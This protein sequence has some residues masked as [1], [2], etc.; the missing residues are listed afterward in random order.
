[1]LFPG[2]GS[3]ESSSSSKKQVHVAATI[4]RR[5]HTF[6][7]QA[8]VCAIQVVIVV[9]GTDGGRNHVI[10]PACRKI[11]WARSD[12]DRQTHFVRNYIQGQ[13]HPAVFWW[14]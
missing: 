6:E 7:Q 4:L 1:M 11:G 9:I 12:A 5:T 10:P 2:S 14:S 8:H 3:P 13:S